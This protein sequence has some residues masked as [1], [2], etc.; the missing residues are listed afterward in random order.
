VDLAL[1]Q[2]SSRRSH[3]RFL[4]FVSAGG[5]PV[6]ERVAELDESIGNAGIDTYVLQLDRAFLG[7]ATP[8]WPF[9]LGSGRI[10]VAGAT[11]ELTSLTDQVA[12]EVLSQRIVS[13]ALEPDET[14]I[15]PVVRI[16]DPA[17]AVDV[18]TLVATPENRA[19]QDYG[20]PDEVPRATPWKKIGAVAL[21]FVLLA[22]VLLLPPR[23]RRRREARR[24]SLPAPSVPV[25]PIS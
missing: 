19:A 8:R 25:L 20:L 7:V 4:V 18:P 5:Y 11:T 9:P 6:D 15:G 14:A 3:G 17:G 1:D 23:F 10:L 21:G 16:D 22:G 13:F 12:A 24:R 2:F